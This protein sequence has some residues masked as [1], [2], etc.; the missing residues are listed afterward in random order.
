MDLFEQ[1]ERTRHFGELFLLWLW[2]HSD[3]DDT[4]FYLS[5][6]SLLTLAIDNQIVLEA[7]LTEAEKT[8]LSGGAPADSREAFEALRQGKVLSQAKMRVQREEKEWVFTLNGAKLEL[9][10][11]KIPAL[12]TKA[13]DDKLFE[14]QALIE[15]VDAL[16]R[17]LYDKFLLVR[18]DP[19]GWK[20]EE[21]NL[22]DWIRRRSQG[23]E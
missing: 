11:L 8:V 21:E 9:S 19:D 22:L 23:E 17:G 18:L 3:I 14:R 4:I 13:D 16:I 15:D 10:G 5:D 20:I 7:K 2:Y 12:M 1:I 6:G